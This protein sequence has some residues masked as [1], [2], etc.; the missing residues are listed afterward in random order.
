MTNHWIDIKNSDVILIMGSNAAE[1]H[2]VSFRWISEAVKNGA[3]LISVDPRFTRTSSKADVYA[4]I[5][6]GTDIAFLG[7]LIKFILDNKLYHEEYVI[8]HTNASYLVN[9]EYSFNAGIFSGFD[10]D[11]RGYEK[12]S[13]WYQM[14]ENGIQKQDPTLRDPHCVM[15]L[16]RKHYQRYDLHTVSGVTGTSEADLLRIYKAMGDTGK[17]NRV[18]TIMYAM[19]WTQHTYGSQNIR[20]ATIIQLLLGNI[21]MAGGGINALRGESNVQGS[22]DHCLLFH[23]LPG[24]L[25]TP[26]SHN[27][28]LAAYLEENTPKC[29]DPRSANWWRNYPK[30]FIS[31]LKWL[32]GDNATADN[33]FGFH[34]LPKMADRA[35]YSWLSLFRAMHA[36]TIKGFFAW[37]QNPAVSGTNANQVRQA[38]G[39][40]DWM[41]AVNLW[42][43]ETSSFWRRPG[44]D[45]AQIKT[46]VFSLPAAVSVEKEGSITNS[47]R[48][49]QWRWKAVEPPG[50]ARADSWIMNQLMIRLR[51]L[52]ERDPGPNP[53]PLLKLAWNYGDDEVD[54]H[55]V[56]GEINGLALRDV[57][58]AEG[59]TVVPAGRRL[60][61]FTQ[62]KD[63]G[64]TACAN[65]LYSGSYN[66]D[67]NMMARRDNMDSHPSGIGLYGNWA[68]AW[69][70]NRRILYNRASCNGQGAPFDPDRFVVRWNGKRWEGDVP[71]GGW[72]PEEKLAFIMRRG[73]RARI[74]GPSMADGPF[75]EHYEPWES[76]AKNPLN[77]QDIN[78]ALWDLEMDAKGATHAYPL[79]GTT[80]RV[81]E[82]WQTGAMTRNVPWLAEMQPD[83]F[84]EM[85]PEL[86][87]ERN[88]ANGERVV[89]ESARGAIEATAI[90]TRR[91]RPFNI[92]G[93]TVH[94]VGMPW[95]WGYCGLVTGG[96]A[97]E[98]TPA[99]GDANTMIPETKAFLCNI[100][101]LA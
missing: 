98:L 11:T 7:G 74:F 97:N 59:N 60:R 1:N 67:G 50:E 31:L 48:W 17:A 51:G 19:G 85:S 24:Y 46:E 82:H 99:I 83:M 9:P 30:Y 34:W 101:K 70:L 75:P 21:G 35:N 29:N 3:T 91:F 40:L 55:L 27:R 37:G 16:L 47:G 54:V 77:N 64:S 15:Q 12:E 94:E 100:R 79:V 26:A 84:V 36:G 61:D 95:H 5:R 18:A 86:A 89:V 42:D 53:D 71:D 78:P 92:N 68:W 20:A 23:I 43:T 62:L 87:A 96:S 72:P 76:P 22:T 28:T 57:T 41:V 44:A 2:P 25:K 63:D 58:D 52:Y 90:V 32:Y 6:S 10:P 49:V 38:L 80:Y 66:E 13:W 14:Q 4:P 81:S 45:P 39:K 56:A 88:I 69:P 73:G 65:W 93:Q 8:Q 33:E